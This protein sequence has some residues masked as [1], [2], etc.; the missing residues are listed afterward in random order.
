MY[1]LP[2]FDGLIFK[3]LVC[4]SRFSVTICRL[5]GSILF[6]IRPIL[7]TNHLQ[8]N[9]RQDAE[10]DPEQRFTYE[11]RTSRKRH[12]HRGTST[13]FWLAEE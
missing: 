4:R 8:R 12:V 11:A 1:S 9:H 13:V 2:S 5:L 10:A 7:T 3:S 6:R